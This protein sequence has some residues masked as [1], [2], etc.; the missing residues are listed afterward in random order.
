MTENKDAEIRAFLKGTSFIR[1]GHNINSGNWQ[2]T[3]MGIRRMEQ[4]CKELELTIFL[5]NLAQLRD[6]AMHRDKNGC[7]QI[8]A[9]IVAKR[10]QMLKT[11]EQSEQS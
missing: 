7:K 5:R 11:L 4:Q 6:A 8:L 9:Q 1:L 10:V 2:V 3:V